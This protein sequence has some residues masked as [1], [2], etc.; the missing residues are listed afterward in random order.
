MQPYLFLFITIVFDILG[1]A[2]LKLSNDFTVL[3]PTL[4]VIFFDVLLYVLFSQV[5]KHFDMSCAY[6]LW[7]ALSIAFIAVVGVFFF[8]EPINALKV[9]SFIIVIIGVVGLQLA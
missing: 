3:Y 7:S 2:C 8:H 4:G 1:T 5:L 6:A 9:V